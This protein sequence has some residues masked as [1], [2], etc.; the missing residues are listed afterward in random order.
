MSGLETEVDGGIWLVSVMDYD[1]G[2]IDLE[3]KTLQPLNNPLGPKGLPMSPG[4]T[5]LLIKNG[6]R[7]SI[8]R[9]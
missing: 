1:L 7:P 3:E 2:Y 5:R 8:P 6:G 9:W 4:R